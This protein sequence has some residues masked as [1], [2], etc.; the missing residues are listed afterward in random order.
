MNVQMTFMILRTFCFKT[1][2]TSPKSTYTSFKVYLCSIEFATEKGKVLVSQHP[3]EKLSP[4][5]I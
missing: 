2:K 3:N 1:D 4:L 5:L